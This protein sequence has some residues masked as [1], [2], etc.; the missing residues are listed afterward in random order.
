MIFVL[1]V[2]SGV[3]LFSQQASEK[4]ISYIPS[5]YGIP[6]EIAG[7]QVLAVNSGYSNPCQPDDEI[8]VLLTYAAAPQD[9]NR[10]NMVLNEI[11]PNIRWQ[12]E[13]ASGGTREQVIANLKR[14]TEMFSGVEM[15]TPFSEPPLPTS[16]SQ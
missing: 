16:S 15:C 5:D 8:T 3:F 9:L 1:V 13:I 2:M 14:I 7:Y 10:V 11:D 4:E 6:D 12:I